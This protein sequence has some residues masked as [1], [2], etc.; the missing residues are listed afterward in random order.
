[1][2][3]GNRSYSPEYR[4]V[5]SYY[6]K[7]QCKIAP[8][9]QVGWW[10]ARSKKFHILSTL[11]RANNP[12]YSCPYMH[13]QHNREFTVNLDYEVKELQYKYKVKT[14]THC[15]PSDAR[16]AHTIYISISADKRY[17]PRPRWDVDDILKLIYARKG[18]I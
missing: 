5:F 15:T 14:T 11:T 18:V 9:L 13:L 3:N 6:P 17:G 2:A 1:M 12:S 8:L 7:K 4:K 10:K 16:I